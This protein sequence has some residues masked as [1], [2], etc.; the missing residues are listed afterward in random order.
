[1]AYIVRFSAHIQ[2]DL[3][4]NWSSWSFGKDGISATRKQMRAIISDAINNDSGFAISGFECWPTSFEEHEDGF[5]VRQGAQKLCIKEL[6]QN[7]WVL[8]DTRYRG[9]AFL[10]EEFE[11]IEDAREFASGGSHDFSEGSFYSAEDVRLVESQHEEGQ[12]GWHI[13][14][15]E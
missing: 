15:I 14:E 13:F 9:I 8:V 7:Y 1:M 4:R 12:Y 10:E 2:K 6:S 5:E 3:D 11:T